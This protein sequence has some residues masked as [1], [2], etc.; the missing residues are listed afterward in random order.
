MHWARLGRGPALS[1]FAVLLPHPHI[2]SMLLTQRISCPSGSFKGEPALRG[3]SKTPEPR[4]FSQRFGLSRDSTRE[5]LHYV[6]VLNAHPPHPDEHDRLIQRHVAGLLARLQGLLDIASGRP[7]ANRGPF[8]ATIR[9]ALRGRF[10]ALKAEVLANPSLEL[11]I[12]VVIIDVLRSILDLILRRRNLYSA[13]LFVGVCK[14][15]RDQGLSHEAEEAHLDPDVLLAVGLVD[16]KVVDLSYLLAR[17]VVNFV[18]V[19]PLFEFLQP[20]VCVHDVSPCIACSRN[21]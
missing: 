9:A 1:Q 3:P 10:L 19:V 20:V 4:Y 18:A 12:D 2:R 14:L 11:L 8:V 21:T 15:H 6:F 16:E 7:F 13:L 5:D 17:V